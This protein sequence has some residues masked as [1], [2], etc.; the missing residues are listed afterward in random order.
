MKFLFASPVRP[1][2]R[3]RLKAV[4]HTLLHTLLQAFIGITVVAQTGSG[5]HLS[6]RWILTI[7][8]AQR[9][10]EHPVDLQ[11]EASGSSRL[12]ML[13]PLGGEDGLF[14]GA[15]NDSRLELAGTLHGAE[16]RINLSMLTQT[17]IG[18]IESDLYKAQISARRPP[19]DGSEVKI[20]DYAKVFE[21]VWK[22]VRENYYDPRLNGLN[23]DE[24]R[25]KYLPLARAARNDGELVLALRRM[26]RELKSSTADFHLS[27]GN[28]AGRLKV[29]RVEWKD[30]SR[31]APNTGYLAIRAFSAEDLYSFDASLDK[32]MDAIG[33]N[34]AVIVDLRGNRGENLEAALDALNI[35][36]PE[37]RSVA[38]FVTREG[39]TGLGVDS[40]DRIDPAKLPAAFVDNPAAIA[41]FKGAGMYLAGGKYKR[42]FGGRYIV[43]ID[44][45]CSGSCE[46]F[47]EAMR[48]AGVAE[49]VGRRTAGALAVSTSV[50][51]TFVQWFRLMKHDVPGWKMTLPMMEIRTAGKKR[52]DGVGIEPDV[53]VERSKTG[54]DAD[55]A[56]ALQRLAGN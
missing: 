2:G 16:A 10:I 24:I 48:E 25:L 33:G 22:G 38:Y 7:E 56:A 3:A 51:F 12:V 5:Q 1:S 17:M 21:G 45:L 50:T 15:F 47:A 42:P 39:L 8:T 35:L 54:E 27:N 6:G 20:G 44:E 52:I 49:L 9:I 11:I 40:I 32:A 43:L 55:L 34:R 28:P 13:G 18:E 19:P 41:Q 23:W 36:L 31:R 29:D 14:R 37:A 4:L 53:K 26:L 30:L 46:L